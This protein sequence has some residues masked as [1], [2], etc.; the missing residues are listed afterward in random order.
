MKFIHLPIFFILFLAFSFFLYT[1]FFHLYFTNTNNKFVFFVISIFFSSSVSSIFP[2][3]YYSISFSPPSSYF[4][5]PHSSL[6]LLPLLF[7]F[8]FFLFCSSRSYS[9]SSSR[10]SS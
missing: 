2:S 9:S 3:S 6:S 1:V 8:L 5:A 4:S 7:L 10:S